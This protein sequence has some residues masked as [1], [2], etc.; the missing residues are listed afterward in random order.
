M[1]SGKKTEEAPGKTEHYLVGPGV[2]FYY[3]GILV[4]ITVQSIKTDGYKYD[5]VCGASFHVGDHSFLF[6][7]GSSDEQSDVSSGFRFTHYCPIHMGT[8]KSLRKWKFLLIMEDCSLQILSIR[9]K[10]SSQF[11]W[12]MYTPSRELICSHDPDD[13]GRGFGHL[14]LPGWTDGFTYSY[15]YRY[16]NMT[17]TGHILKGKCEGTY[18]EDDCEISK[19]GDLEMDLRDFIKSSKKYFKDSR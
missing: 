3:E 16:S 18:C 13:W 8:K 9:I 17:L 15:H 5:I 4:K 14:P 6:E 2:P 7:K 19:S 12:K 1:A 10:N 11:S